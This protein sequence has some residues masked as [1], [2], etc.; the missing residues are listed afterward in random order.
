MCGLAGVI[1][2]QKTRTEKELFEISGAFEQMLVKANVRGGHATGFAIIDKH[3]DYHICKKPLDSFDFFKNPEVHESIDLLYEDVTCLMGHTRYATLGSPSINKNNHPLRTGKTIGTHNGSIHNHKYLFN[4]FNMKRFAQVDSEAIFR[5]YDESKSVKDFTKNRLK[6]VRGKVAIVW[7]DLEFPDYVY[8]LKANNPLKMAYIPE[9][10]IFAYGSTDEILTFPKWEH[11]E[12]I[13][14]DSNTML[15]INTKNLTFEK[16]NIEITE[17]YARKNV[18]Y[19]DSNIGAYRNT[20][21]GFIPRFSY[22]D[23]QTSLWKKY[24]ANDGST[25]RKIK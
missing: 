20:V 18:G 16:T 1:L 19:Y 21:S 14:I 5:L 13:N 17:P 12:P 9:F 6:K 4:K 25:I 15:R 2:K 7:A 11:Y 23:K 24:L 10:D 22:S 8:I 3:G